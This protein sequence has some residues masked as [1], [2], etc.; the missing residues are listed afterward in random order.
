M[1]CEVDL[2]KNFRVRV[3]RLQ[4]CVQVQM[5]SV[6]IQVQQKW[7]LVWVRTRVLQ[8]WI[9]VVNCCNWWTP[10]IIAVFQIDVILT[11]HLY[12]LLHRHFASILYSIVHDQW[13]M[14]VTGS[15]LQRYPTS[16]TCSY[17]LSFSVVYSAID[18][19]DLKRL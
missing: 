12:A 4:V 1:V 8:V 2:L 14:S 7:T 10:I 16:N 5:L 13:L 11:I 19:L 15:V 18:C 6:Q 9:L 17:V 3:H